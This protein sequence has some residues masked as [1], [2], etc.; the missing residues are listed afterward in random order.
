AA[1]SAEAE[2]GDADESTPK[3]E[4]KHESPANEVS[5]E[6]AEAPGDK[7]DDA[8]KQD[9]DSAAEPTAT[10]EAKPDSQGG[11]GQGETDDSPSQAKDSA[12][13]SGEDK[14]QEPDE[15][16]TMVVP[17]V[18]GMAQASASGT[19][20]APTEGKA[21]GAENDKTGPK[22]KRK[23]RRGIW[24]LAAVLALAAIVGGG[25]AVANHYY[26]DKAA[27]GA[28]LAGLSVAGMTQAELEKTAAQVIEGLQ[29]TI[30]EGKDSVTGNAAQL[31]VSADPKAV[32]LEA[33]QAAK[34]KPLW[35]RLNPWSPKNIGITAQVDEVK[36][37]AYL[38]QAFIAEAERSKD[39]DVTFNEESGQF[40]VIPSFTGQRTD[41]SAAVTAIHNY[42]T[43]TAAPTQ[44]KVTSRDNPPLIT[45]EAAAQAAESA[46]A[47]LARKLTFTNGEGDSATMSYELPAASITGWTQF[48][49][50]PE[51]GQ[52]TVSY[53][54]DKM[55][56]ELPELLA[57][58]VAVPARPQKVITH[59]T[60]GND[61]GVVQWGLNGRKM[62]DPT[63]VI[64]QTL[65]ALS[66]GNDAVI[67]V[68]TEAEPFTTER[69]MPPTNYDEP[70]GAHWIDVNKSTFR[71]T[72][73]AGTTEVGSYIISIGRPGM[74]TPSGTHY[75][76]LKYDYQVM[77]GPASDPYES[78]TNWVSYFSGGVAFH[79]APWNEPNRWG[80]R[81]SHGC[82]NMKTAH[83]KAVY[84]FAPIGTK[85]VVHD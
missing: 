22:A 54:V 75:V 31:G 64:E 79:S 77:R 23:R 27:P 78:P 44:V 33:L 25:V 30:T 47:G 66:A 48:T 36:L 14:G 7:A 15:T 42:L 8:P 5:V 41:V 12:V 63:Q 1:D 69:S 76:Y 45:D 16:A 29:L 32:A 39:A 17:A 50:E 4:D 35:H 58:K 59:P 51:N 56:A 46:N 11:E 40:E 10:D 37:A 71:A 84:D 81:I 19:V 83:A 2:S 21:K 34:S 72:L 60:T 43:D 55:T 49:A 13:G 65:G 9:D 73:Y 3:S 52:I 68:D 57:D 6:D 85:V 82:V 70:N 53:D 38:D 28:T 26:K 67:V 61:L 20:A 62:A 74:D 18:A 80:M 24:L